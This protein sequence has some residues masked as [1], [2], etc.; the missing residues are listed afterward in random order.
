MAKGSKKVHLLSNRQNKNISYST[1]KAISVARGQWIIFF[2]QDDL[3]HESALRT[4][5]N[6]LDKNKRAKVLYTDED[7][8][9]E[10]DLHFD[11]YF[12]PD[13]NPALLRSQNYFCHLLA[14][15]KRHLEEC[16]KLREGYE[17]SQD[18]D[19]CLR[20]TKELETCEVVHIPQVLYHWRSHDGSTAKS[21]E[22]KGSS[23]A[24][25]S[26]KVLKD[27]LSISK[28]N[29][30]VEKVDGIHW[31]IRKKLP[32][33]IP[34]LL[35][36]LVENNTLASFDRDIHEVLLQTEYHGEINVIKIKK[37]AVSNFFFRIKNVSIPL[38]AKRKKS[39]FICILSSKVKPIKS[40][41]LS[42]MVA[43][44][45]DFEIGFCGPKLV[46]KDQNTIFSCGLVADS[47]GFIKSMYESSPLSFPGD[48]FRAKL[49]QNFT[50]IHPGCIV[51]RS[52]L[53]EE[54]FDPF[55]FQSVMESCLSLHLSGKRNLLLP[56][57]EMDIRD[58]PKV[59]Y[60]FSNNQKITDW[61]EQVS[62]DP[63]FN[64]NLTIKDGLPNIF[65][66]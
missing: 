16:G 38:A 12:K 58:Y 43:N 66:S 2:D 34:S 57:V 23:I 24:N 52:E 4:I 13:W 33:K 44:A 15:Q 18:W 22:A 45:M 30:S 62:Y 59:C 1:N 42:D 46:Q 25:S 54:N 41:W 28:I 51:G 53:F 19:L 17:G 61:F 36:V 63:T 55:S 20:L 11:P 8:V 3:L 40:S 10:N 26:Q 27:F 39:E 50:F 37:T 9:D 31:N 56:E 7:K 48:K 35:L 21:I 47:D 5:S 29:A 64:P 14:V 65:N 32:S 49:K 60:D 6:Y